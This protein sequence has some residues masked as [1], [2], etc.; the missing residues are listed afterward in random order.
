MVQLSAKILENI[1]QKLHENSTPKFGKMQPQQMVEHLEQNFE[2]SIG[3]IKTIVY[4]PNEKLS[5]WKAFLMSDLP[6]EPYKSPMHK[7]GLPELRYSDL[8]TAKEKM[9][10]ALEEYKNFYKNNP[11]V[12]NPNPMFGEL[13]YAEWDR[14]HRK[15]LM[16]HFK[17]FKLIQ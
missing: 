1:L 8:E 14:F 15:H 11:G 2:L 17:Q 7:N 9:L 16:H 3:K 10:V 4:T 6:F 13:N 5:K 12:T